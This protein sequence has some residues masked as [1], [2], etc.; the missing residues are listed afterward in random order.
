MVEQYIQRY[1]DAA[2]FAYN[3][4]VHQGH[5]GTELIKP[6]HQLEFNKIR[7]TYKYATPFKSPNFP[8]VV[9]SN[10][11]LVMLAFRGTVQDFREPE[12]AIETIQRWL[13]NFNYAQVE[14]DCGSVHRGFHQELNGCY[15][16]IKRIVREHGGHR[17][18]LYVTGHS[19]GGAM[20]L[21]AARQL[22]EDG[23]SPEPPFIFSAPRVGSKRYR[24]TYPI[25]VYRFEYQHDLIPHLPFSPVCTK[26][27]DRLGKDA[28]NAIA[29]LVP[30]VGPYL[31]RNVE[32]VHVGKLYYVDENGNCSGRRCFRLMNGDR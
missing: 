4:L 12:R 8:G 31:P 1:Y 14:L 2:N 23:Y 27:M 13:C 10:D 28:W 25:N 30:Q 3:G 15:D 11:E 19:A 32:Y 26:L 24:D 6:H 16:M 21:L 18:P 17:K 22:H 20:A 29:E 7:R 5:T 9:I